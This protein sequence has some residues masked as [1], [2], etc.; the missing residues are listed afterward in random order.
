MGT[1]LIAGKVKNKNG[2]IVDSNLYKN[3]KDIFPKELADKYYFTIT[4]DKFKN[5][6]NYNHLSFDENNEP[7]IDSL[8]THTSIKNDISDNKM[9]KSILS[10]LKYERSG[11]DYYSQKNLVNDVISLNKK[12]STEVGGKQFYRV[13]LIKEYNEKTKITT[14]KA[15]AYKADPATSALWDHKLNIFSQALSYLDENVVNNKMTQPLANEISYKAARALPDR[16]SDVTFFNE[17]TIYNI[18]NNNKNDKKDKEGYIDNT[19]IAS[20]TN[21][22]KRAQ[23]VMLNIT[24]DDWVDF[25]KN[26]NI[27][28]SEDDLRNNFDKYK[29]RLF[30]LVRKKFQVNRAVLDFIRNKYTREAV[31]NRLN[32]LKNEVDRMWKDIDLPPRTENIKIDDTYL[33][34]FDNIK[35]DN[36]HYIDIKEII[37][38][39]G[40]K[41]N[42]YETSEKS[43][44]Q[45][46]KKIIEAE[47]NEDYIQ[48]RIGKDENNWVNSEARKHTL[49]NLIDLYENGEYE[50]ALYQYYVNIEN[51]LQEWLGKI[52]NLNLNMY[53]Q[54][55]VLRQIH[56]EV[57]LYGQISDYFKKHNELLSFDVDKIRDKIL[58]IFNNLFGGSKEAFDK[59]LAFRDNKLAFRDEYPELEGMARAYWATKESR[60]SVTNLSTLNNKI[61]I[62][63]EDIKDILYKKEKFI[64]TKV[65][66]SFQQD[67]AKV[68]PFGNNKGHVNDIEEMLSRA[69][70]D[71]YGIER[72]LDSMAESPDMILRLI[73]NITKQFKNTAR[74]KSLEF[75]RL[76]KKEA[77]LLE[78]AGV[79]GTEWMF[80]KDSNGIKTGR[81][82]VEGDIEYSEIQ[83]N[84]AKK[85]F[86]DFF[87]DTKES[88]DAMYPDGTVK[89]QAIINIR[90][91]FMERVKDSKNLKEAIN[92][93][94]ETIKDEWLNKNSGREDIE[95]YS[96]GSYTLNGEEVNILPIYYQGINFKD[97][98]ELNEISED[99]VSTLIAYGAKSFDYNESNKIINAIELTKELLKEREIPVI[100]KGKKA[101]SFIKTMLSQEQD[102]SERQIYYKDNGSSNLSKRLQGYL[103]CVYYAKTRKGDISIGKLSA[104][105]VVDKFNAYTARATMSLSLLNGISNVTTG[106]AMMWY[107]TFSKKYFKPKDNLWAKKTYAQN[108]VAMM[109]N[110]GCRIK[111]DKLSL[112]TELFDVTNKYD[113]S[114]LNN[115][116]WDKRTKLGRLEFGEA[117]M[118]MQDAGEHWMSHITALSVA[119]STKLIDKDGKSINLWDALE[120][121]Y[122]QED[123][124]Y[125]IENKHLGA[126]LVVKDGVVKPDGSKVTSNDIIKIQTKISGIN[127]KMHGVYNK[128]DMNLIQT[129]AVGRAAYLFRKWM[130]SS[131]NKRFSK[132]NYD[133]ETGEW[134]EGYYRSCGRFL[135]SLL[136][137]V[138][139]AKVDIKL[140]W[141]ELHPVEKANV[142]QALAETL[143]LL[144]M[145][146]ANMLIDWGDDDDKHDKDNWAYNMF[147]YQSIR[148]QSELSSLT[149]WGVAH[150]SI[151]LMK[152]PIPMVNILDNFLTTT[153]ALWIPNWFEEETRGMFKGHSQGFKFLMGNKVINPYYNI[154]W[155]TANVETQSSWYK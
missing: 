25:I 47:V 138:K 101:I 90:K 18:V 151:R 21:N 54:A 112:F 95:G 55:K 113:K 116:E 107:E 114:Q 110:L 123:G 125:G 13:A 86:Y 148:L 70:R 104:I 52:N 1:C 91:D 10:E 3:L 133:Y 9:S 60:D 68:V 94:T 146:A 154:W 126:K 150:E 93:Y 45:L 73:D 32:Y 16:A 24:V 74:L 134:D 63:L 2:E 87:M 155:R 79:I 96:Q 108:M 78:K 41:I 141:N 62:S 140:H 131:A 19:T 144:G 12:L 7:T 37:K 5:H 46:I 81:Y 83:N 57:I 143:V 11:T 48:T 106:T 42:I 97:T 105:K 135:L 51:K 71:M 27:D 129:T 34:T 72:L 50:L 75:A 121:K 111:D 120:V 153:K 109:G 8:L 67:N 65:L 145:I 31:E 36:E 84:P 14:I 119:S 38:S 124:S 92:S 35:Q 147:L 23:A 77:A 29:S 64:V 80:K 28:I 99:A 30:S 39:L 76:V 44:I 66:N 122:L 103:D 6:E 102:E 69:D 40:D 56:Y 20:D 137:D 142:K 82:V 128:I 130:W 22:F 100:D 53:E 85:R 17:N 88:L 118:F 58:E 115:I 132:V 59:L 136:K 26:E 152:S 15:V 4:S 149:P 139:Q 89:P 43:A 127:H 61:I 33:N 117:L 49:E 98:K